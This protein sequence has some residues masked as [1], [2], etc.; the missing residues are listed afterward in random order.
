QLL[1]QV[2]GAGAEPFGQITVRAGKRDGVEMNTVATT[3]GVQPVGRVVRVSSRQC[4]IRLINEVSSSN[5]KLKG[6]IMLSDS[7]RGPVCLLSAVTDGKLQGVVGAEAGD[8]A[9]AVG[10]IVR[11][12]DDKWPR[13]AQMLVI[14]SIQRVEP[15]STGRHIT[16]LAPTGALELPAAA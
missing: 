12:V 5:V 2:I 16:P 15:D 10:Q 11:L 4:D 1:R 9:P 3:V 7:A 6:V 8:K 14:G 13:S